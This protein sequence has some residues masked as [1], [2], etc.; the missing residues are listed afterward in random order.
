MSTTVVGIF[1]SFEQAQQ[2]AQEIEALGVSRQSVAIARGHEGS[3]YAVYGGEGAEDYSQPKHVKG[4]ISGFFEGL[5][6]SDVDERDRGL[7]SE[8]ARRGRTVVTATVADDQS[9]R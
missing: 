9:E 7:Y 8:A 2:A 5:F 4:G 1:D 3:D 6:G